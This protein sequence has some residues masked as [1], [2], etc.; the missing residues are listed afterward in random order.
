MTWNRTHFICSQCFCWG[1]GHSGCWASPRGSLILRPDIASVTGWADGCEAH[2]RTQKEAGS[3]VGCAPHSPGLPCSRQHTPPPTWDPALPLGDGGETTI[4]GTWPWTG[5]ERV[6]GLRVSPSDPGLPGVP[7][8]THFPTQA[9]DSLSGKCVVLVQW[10]LRFLHYAQSRPQQPV[11]TMSR[12]GGIHLPVTSQVC[13]PTSCAKGRASVYHSKH[14][15]SHL[16]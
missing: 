8:A 10:P 7:E 6:P 1:R 15:F 12:G 16:Q 3:P 9:P 4:L 11:P 5:E 14:L 13:L 2:S